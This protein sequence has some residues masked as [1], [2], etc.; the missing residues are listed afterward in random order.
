MLKGKNKSWLFHFF[1]HLSILASH[2]FLIQL[3]DMI[4]KL[5][6]FFPID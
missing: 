2:F 6:D 3:K 5:I 4:L 1:P